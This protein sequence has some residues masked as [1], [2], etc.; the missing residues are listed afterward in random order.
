LSGE[1]LG[2]VVSELLELAP[3]AVLVNCCSPSASVRSAARLARNRSPMGTAWKFGVYPNGGEP[4]PER[5]YH[6]ARIVDVDEFLVAVEGALDLGATIVGSCCG[7]TPR[8]TR[9][10]R[11]LID[12]RLRR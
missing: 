3:E 10:I 7:T 5:G 11:Y 9:A 6:D 8:Y 1:S 4:H 12:G 2:E